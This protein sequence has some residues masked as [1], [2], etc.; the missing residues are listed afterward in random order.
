MNKQVEKVD[1][2]FAEGA[3]QVAQGWGWW[4]TDSLDN[5]NI[6]FVV[7]L[8]FAAGTAAVAAALGTLK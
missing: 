8:T 6:A 4:E 3:V 1:T 5:K 2:A 7:A